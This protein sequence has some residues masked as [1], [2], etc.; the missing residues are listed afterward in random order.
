MKGLVDLQAVDLEA[1]EVTKR[2]KAGAEIVD[3]DGNLLLL[4]LVEGRQ[5][6][7]G[8]EHRDRFRDFE[9]KT[10]G[11]DAAFV[12]SAVDGLDEAGVAKL[13]DRDVDRHAEIS[14]TIVVEPLEIMACGSKHP[15]AEP[16]NESGAFGE[17]DEF[18]GRN[19]VAIFRAPP[20]QRLDS[21]DL[22]GTE[23]ILRLVDDEQAL[24]VERATQFPQES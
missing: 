1:F 11:V 12:D 13:H 9:F 7:S 17:R 6:E 20:Q 16:D 8:V 10:L 14:E 23:A 2:R 4:E 15:G 22:T 21:G 18:V 19:E 5:H 3:G 24:S